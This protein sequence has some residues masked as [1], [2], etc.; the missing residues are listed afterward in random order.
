[1]FQFD[2]YNDWVTGTLFGYLLK[3]KKKRNGKERFCEFDCADFIGDPNYSGSDGNNNSVPDNDCR[4]NKQLDTC[5]S[6]SPNS[7]GVYNCQKESRDNNLVREGL[8]KKY[9]GELY[10]AANSTGQ[11]TGLHAPNYKLFATDIICLGSVFSCDWQG[12]PKL[13]PSLVA[14]S[15][16]MPP[17][18]EELDDNNTTVLATGQV[19]I[20]N[21][22]QDCF[23]I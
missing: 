19:K 20:G 22:A 2:F 15:Y 17:E 9:K 12:Y 7:L 5:Y 6:C 4:N 23:L 3:Y 1:M 10:Y 16:K 13:Q 21:G 8:V 18:I 11:V 14:S